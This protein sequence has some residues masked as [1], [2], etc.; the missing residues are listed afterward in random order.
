MKTFQ[1]RK[2][3]KT[4]LLAKLEEYKTELASLRVAQ[5]SNGAAS[6]LAKM[7]IFS[8]NFNSKSVRKSIARVSTVIS[9]TQREQLK[10][11]YAGKKY[12][13]LDLRA[14]KTRAIRRKLTLHESSAVSERSRKK[15]MHFPMRKY[16]VAL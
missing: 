9:Q 8:Y 15:S 3:T 7:Y 1:L 11:Y 13:P 6:K 2:E 10:I 16:A 14:K 12:Q 4:S 5:I